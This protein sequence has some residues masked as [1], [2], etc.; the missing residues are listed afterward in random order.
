MSV[1]QNI[2]NKKM[3]RGELRK[4]ET[5]KKIKRER[6]K[7]NRCSYSIFSYPNFTLRFSKTY[8]YIEVTLIF[9]V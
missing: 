4:F 8:L 7:K 9:S 3:M 1:G 5:R 2:E 6:R